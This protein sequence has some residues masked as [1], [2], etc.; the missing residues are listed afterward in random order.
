MSSIKTE[1]NSVR[2]TVRKDEQLKIKEPEEGS[3]VDGSTL[4]KLES[5]VLD[6]QR[7][8]HRVIEELRKVPSTPNNP[9]IRELLPLPVFDSYSA[10]DHNTSASQGTIRFKDPK[11]LKQNDKL[12]YNL[13]YPFLP[14]LYDY[15]L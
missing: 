3:L 6:I 11:R 14:G 13:G 2:L 12:G 7:G 9:L 4:V 5:A 1:L 15:A 8:P 10:A